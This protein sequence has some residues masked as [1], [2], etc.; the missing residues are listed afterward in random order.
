MEIPHSPYYLDLLL[1]HDP[2]DLYDLFQIPM[3]LPKS[4]LYYLLLHLTNKS[5]LCPADIKLVQDPLFPILLEQDNLTDNL[6]TFGLISPSPSTVYR[7]L[8]ATKQIKLSDKMMFIPPEIEYPSTDQIPKD[9]IL[10]KRN[11]IKAQILAHNFNNCPNFTQLSVKNLHYL[12][13]LYDFEFFNNKLN[14]HLLLTNGLLLFDI[15]DRMTKTAGKCKSI[16]ELHSSGIST[17]TYSIKISTAII[18][19]TFVSKNSPLA[20]NGLLCKDRI[21]CLMIVFEH[22]LMH[23]V[24]RSNINISEPSAIYSSHGKLFKQLVYAYFNHTGVTHGLLDII[25][26]KGQFKIGD[27]VKFTLSKQGLITGTIKKL[28]PKRAVI[29]TVEATYYVNYSLLL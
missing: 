5:L 17:S 23:F 29:E 12:Y 28:N 24:I 4:R 21:D 20:C 11:K 9:L 26:D 13:Q 6:G 14:H 27:S 25:V 3:C 19:D 8:I 2:L 22:E 16:K 1:S 15:S 18:L 10:Y 7:V